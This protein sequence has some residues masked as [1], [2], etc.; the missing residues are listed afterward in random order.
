MARTVTRVALLIA[1]TRYYRAVLANVAVVDRKLPIVKL[2]RQV[3]RKVEISQSIWEKWPDWW[4]TCYCSLCVDQCLCDQLHTN[5]GKHGNS[6]VAFMQ[7]R[8]RI[9]NRSC[10]FVQTQVN[11]QTY[12]RIT[13]TCL[14][15]LF[16]KRVISDKAFS[17]IGPS[18]WNKFP[19]LNI[20]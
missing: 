6:C 16:T 19:V 14:V 20:C 18:L 2:Q 15:V 9:Q 5:E 12:S 11:N 8:Y 4:W 10:I 17:V 1:R 13:P 7:S 3:L